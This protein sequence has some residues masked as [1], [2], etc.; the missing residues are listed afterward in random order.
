MKET[1]PLIEKPEVELT[2]KISALEHEIL[3]FA[4]LRYKIPIESFIEK[5]VRSVVEGISV[6][7]VNLPSNLKPK[8]KPKK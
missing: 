3:S 4:S 5:A 1:P 2:I 7:G 6:S 8:N